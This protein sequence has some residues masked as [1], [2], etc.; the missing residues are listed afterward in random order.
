MEVSDQKIHVEQTREPFKKEL[1]LVNPGS[2]NRWNLI[3]RSEYT[4]QKTG[5]S[6]KFFQHFLFLLQL[7]LRAGF[8]FFIVFHEV[9][10][11]PKKRFSKQ[12][13]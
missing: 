10:Y 8:L 4:H 1:K 11:D 6:S 9:L 7:T 12:S 13:S 5:D 2:N 3:N